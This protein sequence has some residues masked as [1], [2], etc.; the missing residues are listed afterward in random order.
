[1]RIRTSETQGVVIAN[2]AALSGAIDFSAY[3]GMSILIPAV[4]TSAAI[5]F[6]VCDT[7]DG[8]FYP[9]YDDEGTLVEATVA[10][11]TK[12]AVP[13]TVFP[14]R[15]VKLW[16]ENAGADENQGAERSISVTLKA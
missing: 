10:V 2:G 4:W 1:M 14:E 16:S 9:L 15:F 12:V 5:G 8:T 11:D 7:V 3:S 6:Y 13:V